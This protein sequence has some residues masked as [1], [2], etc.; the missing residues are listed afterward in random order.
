MRN[1]WW[2][3]PRSPLVALAAAAVLGLAA[4]G[5]LVVVATHDSGSPA[6][7]TAAALPATSDYHS[8]LAVPG[9][10]ERL[11]LGT[12]QGLYRS[13][14]GGRTWSFQGLQGEDAMNLARGGGQTVWAAGHDL[15]AKST[16]GGTTWEDVRPAGLPSLDV[17][18]FAVDPRSRDLYAAVAGRGLYRSRDGGRTFGAVSTSVGGGVMA[19]AV[20]PQPRILAGDMRQGLLGSDDGGA[21]WRQLLPAQVV[22]L[23]VNPQDASRIVAAGR[24]IL[25]SE[26]GGDTWD[27]VLELAAGAGPVT[28]A[29]AGR[30]AY[31]VGFDKKLYRSSDRGR[32]WS[33]VGAEEAR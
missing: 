31:V 11:L 21:S 26:D 32:T 24:G 8:L 28:W 33:P 17:H 18:A 14:D 25:L 9:S 3:R 23:A 22:G 6:P 27:A 19:L 7:S 20:T 5:G 1:G 13:P 15:L 4:A 2:S 16:D 12:H 29:T 30:T 10:P